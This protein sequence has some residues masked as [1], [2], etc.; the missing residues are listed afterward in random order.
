MRARFAVPLGLMCFIWLSMVGNAGACLWLRGT[1]IYGQYVEREEDFL[2]GLISQNLRGKTDKLP[3]ERKLEIIRQQAESNDPVDQKSDAAVEALM[4][5]DAQKAVAMLEALEKEHPGRYYTAANLGTAYELSGNDEKAL[6]W[7]LEGIRRNPD[8]HMKT[9]WLHARIL[10]TKIK[11]KSDPA[12]LKSHT[13]T[14]ADFSRLQDPTY[15][16][17]TIQ[18][19]VDGKDLHRS[20][21]TQLEVRMLFV[22]PADSIVAQLLKELALVEAQIGIL[23]EATV[24]M[25][26]AEEYGMPSSEWQSNKDQWSRVILWVKFKRALPV[27]SLVAV[28]LLGPVLVGCLM[29]K[30]SQIRRRKEAAMKAA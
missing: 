27:I 18:R 29:W 14:E 4:D 15:K 10:E 23:E 19:P 28:V 21:W 25:E 26:M 6:Q 3:S 1:T 9:E 30:A 20:L 12:W 17:Q 5:G 8:S 7:I 13:I 22:K 2:S 16:L 11:L 24:Y